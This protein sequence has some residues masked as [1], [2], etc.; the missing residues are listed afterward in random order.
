MMPTL[1]IAKFRPS[2][3]VLTMDQ[4]SSLGNLTSAQKTQIMEQMK[5][6]VAIASARDLMDV[7]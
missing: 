3:T 6:E 2:R 1:L 4:Q 7:R 5:A